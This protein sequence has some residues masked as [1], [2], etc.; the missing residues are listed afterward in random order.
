MSRF[1]EVHEIGTHISQFGIVESRKVVPTHLPIS[2]VKSYLISPYMRYD[3]LQ[4]DDM[5]VG[6]RP[7]APA[8]T[9]DHVSDA[10]G[11]Q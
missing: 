4:E 2:L 8:R 11:D 6:R 3:L 10:P 9:N 7:Y 1:S 5:L